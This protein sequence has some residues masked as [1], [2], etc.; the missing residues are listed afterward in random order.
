MRVTL[1]CA[2]VP[3]CISFPPHV[4]RSACLCLSLVTRVRLRPRCVCFA[5]LPNGF[6]GTSMTLSHAMDPT[7]DVMV[8]FEQN[9]K[10]LMPDH[11][12]PVRII[13]PGWIG[14][15][16]VKWLTKITVTEKESDNY[17]HFFDNRIL[18]PQVPPPQN[19]AFRP[20]AAQVRWPPSQTP[21]HFTCPQTGGI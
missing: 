18:P 3:G 2:V 11:G 14:W 7:M 19:T 8:A 10:R 5:Q 21:H 12:Y 16:S 4:Q 6:Y 13:I 1:P 15:R 20:N 17:Y 9:G